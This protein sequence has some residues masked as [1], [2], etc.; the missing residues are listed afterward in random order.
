MCTFRNVSFFALDDDQ[1]IKFGF[2][3][4]C[5]TMILINTFIDTHKLETPQ[6]IREVN[7]YINKLKDEH[8]DKKQ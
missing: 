5:L 3:E 4:K 2:C 8:D 6:K 7:E 1:N